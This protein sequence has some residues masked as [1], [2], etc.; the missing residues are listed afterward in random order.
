VLTGASN[1]L[2]LG[3]PDLPQSVRDAHSDYR[4]AISD[5][6]SAGRQAERDLTELHEKRDLIPVQGLNRLRQ[7]AVSEAQERAAEADRRAERALERLKTELTAAA[8]PTLDPARE[9]LARDELLVALGDARE[10]RAVARALD[11]AKSGS[12]EAVAALFSSYGTATLKARGVADPERAL[13]PVRTV[14]ASVAAERGKTMRELIAG[15]AVT[16]VGKLAAARGSA[17]LYVRHAVRS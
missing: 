8:L 12:T 16:R 4:T 1:E 14:A 15:A 2:A 6:I 5:V 3:S 9:A 11:I 17:G 13:A 7:E 10:N